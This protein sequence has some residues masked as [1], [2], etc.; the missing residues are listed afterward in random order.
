MSE[1]DEVDLK[2][3]DFV[4]EAENRDDDV[5]CGN[6]ADT[7]GDAGRASSDTAEDDGGNSQIE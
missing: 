4:L 5:D 7:S 6:I 2:G 1:R 3:E